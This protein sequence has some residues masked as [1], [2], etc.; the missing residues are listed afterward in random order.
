MG[1]SRLKWQSENYKEILRTFS[2]KRMTRG[3]DQKTCSRVP[4]SEWDL[5]EDSMEGL[6]GFCTIC[7]AV[8]SLPPGEFLME[9]LCLMDKRRSF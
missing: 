7:P 2:Q 5:Q 9:D 8:Y 1:M 3:Q 4:S 6:R